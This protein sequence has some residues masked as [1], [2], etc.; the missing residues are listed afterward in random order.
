[1][2]SK[3]HAPSIKVIVAY[4]S[5]KGHTKAQA[6]AV[7]AGA[8]KV[9]GAT[10]QLINVAGNELNWDEFQ[11][12][13]AII[14][15]APTYMGSVSAQMK[16]FMDASIGQWFT[17]NWKDKVAAGFTNSAHASGDKLVSLTTIAIFAAQHG[18]HWV[19]LGLMPS[20]DTDTSKPRNL[21]RL[22]SWLGAMSQSPIG[23][24]TPPVSDLKTAEALGERVAKVT[25]QLKAGKA[26]LGQD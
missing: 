15:G 21:N 14:F 18:M 16:I 7:L 10:V 2:S 4:H 17:Q 26:A 8:Q 5:G 22:S 23:E 20:D 1:M 24:D 6:E 3:V 11:A 25:Q 9:A 13:D 12:A 19:N